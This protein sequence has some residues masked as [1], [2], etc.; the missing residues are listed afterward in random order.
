MSYEF[1]KYFQDEYIIDTKEK[2][3][4]EYRLI[5]CRESF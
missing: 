2:I 5:Q 4:G 3:H 1:E